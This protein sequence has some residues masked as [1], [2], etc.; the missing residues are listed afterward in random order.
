M[1]GRG[2]FQGGAKGNHGN[3]RVGA[4]VRSKGAR[5]FLVLAVMCVGL[6]CVLWHDALP[7]HLVKQWAYAGGMTTTPVAVAGGVPVASFVSTTGEQKAMGGWDRVAVEKEEE[8]V[9]EKVEPQEKGGL[10]SAHSAA[11]VE[12]EEEEEEKWEA[13]MEEEEEEEEEDDQGVDDDGWEE[14]EDDDDWGEDDVAELEEEESWMETQFDDDM[15]EEVGKKAAP[16]RAVMKEEEEKKE[17][18]P[19]SALMEK[20]AEKEERLSARPVKEETVE[21]EEEEAPVEAIKKEEAAE[22]EEAVA[23]PVS[24]RKEEEEEEDEE[25]EA[26]AERLLVECEADFKRTFVPKQKQ[27]VPPVLY[28]FPGTYVASIFFLQ[29]LPHPSPPPPPPPPLPPPLPTLH[30]Q[31]QHLDAAPHRFRLRVLHG[32]H[33]QCH[34]V[35]PRKAARARALRQAGG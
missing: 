30:R 17:E 31:R 19:V 33:L 6:V 27:M 10:D 29:P 9:E 15:E 22:E 3:G 24:A 16:A 25:V 12:V 7:D 4:L 2:F 18:A 1:W 32:L 35:N 34:Q 21:K 26:E 8:P 28:S 23:E 14:E 5:V 20:E 13:T 11:A